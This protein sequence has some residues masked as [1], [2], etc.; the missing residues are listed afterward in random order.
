MEDF[1]NGNPEL[2]NK[3]NELVAIARKVEN[4]SGGGEVKIRHTSNGINISVDRQRASGGSSTPELYWAECA[5]DAPS[6]ATITC[7]IINPSTSLAGSQA[8]LDTDDADNKETTPNTVGIPST[9]HGF[10]VGES[11]TIDGTTSYDGVHVILS[12][13]DD[14]FVISDPNSSFTA[15]TFAI[16]DT[17]TT[18][19]FEENV[20]CIIINSSRLDMA[21][22]RLIE[23]TV[24]PIGKRGITW[25][26]L[27]T[28][29]GSDDFWEIEK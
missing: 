21:M 22:P 6:S 18:W 19:G 26:A 29:M 17:A 24:I 3:L 1:R 7:N 12:K 28:F 8:T 2:K 5:E 25:Y 20:H 4:I 9:A 13:T 10:A 16:T 14:E 27:T 23:D 15:E 11:V